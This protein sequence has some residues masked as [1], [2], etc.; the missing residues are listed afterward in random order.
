MLLV[1]ELYMQ[2][3][4]LNIFNIIFLSVILSSSKAN[5]FNILFELS[6]YLV[7]NYI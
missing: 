4:Q 6:P 7:F 5:S 3:F 1:K 2:R